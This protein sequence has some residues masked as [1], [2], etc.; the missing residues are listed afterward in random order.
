MSASPETLLELRDVD[1]GYGGR[2]VLSNL[3]MHFKRGQVVAVM[4]GSGCGKTTVLR[5]IGGLVK[6][7]RGQVLFGDKDVGTQNRDGLYEL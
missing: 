1:F 7:K 6:A 2:L 3:N 5:L 4:G